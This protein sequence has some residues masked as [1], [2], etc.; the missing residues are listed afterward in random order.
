MNPIR[1]RSV[2]A[3]LILSGVMGETAGAAPPPASGEAPRIQV[4]ALPAP[5]AP[6]GRAALA[7]A[8]SA[9]PAAATCAVVLPGGARM[10]NITA[11][12][13]VEG[14]RP[15]PAAIQPPACPPAKARTDDRVPVVTPP[16]GARVETRVVGGRRVQQLSLI[17]DTP[18]PLGSAQP[19]GP[20][21]EVRQL[22]D[23]RQ[24]LVLPDPGAGR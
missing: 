18:A 2:I 9:T 11:P 16:E 23:G 21:P 6:V 15:A 22:P 24:M 8:P 13:P 20:V 3:L 19:G 7:A 12:G 14:D 10:L 1:S 17:D 4:Q 5:P